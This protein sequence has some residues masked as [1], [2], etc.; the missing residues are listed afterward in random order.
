MVVNK[1]LE[2][3]EIK[4]MG[5]TQPYQKLELYVNNG[6]LEGKK[7]IVE[8]GK[9][10][11]TNLPKYK[12]GD[13]LLV[14]YKKSP[15]GKES[16]F[17][18]DYLRRNSLFW[19]FLI[20]VIVTILIAKFKGLTSLLGMSFSFL[21]VFYFILP[22]IIKGKDPLLTTIIAS[23]LIVPITFYLSHGL[24]KKTTVAVFSTLISLII[25][26]ILAN[27]FVSISKLTGLA[28]EEAGF[29]KVLTGKEIN[30]RGLLLSGIII[31]VI[32]VIDD[33][34]IYQAAIVWQIKE[35]NEKLGFSEVY[36]RAMN[37]GCDHIASM[38]N[39]LVLVYTGV[40]LPL[41]LLFINNPRPFAEVINYEIIASE[42]VR[43]LVGSLGLILA[44][45]IT[46]LVASFV[47]ENGKKIASL[48]GYNS[49]AVYN[50]SSFSYVAM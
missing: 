29:L 41:F 24:N 43:T 36:K 38:I 33:I 12:V 11:L 50:L 2:E 31:G 42:I 7:I 14:S 10:P 25:T 40:S 44:V 19:L 48:T 4:V 35:L 39:T 37:V 47:T 13:E 49:H 27:F 23:L 28:T 32:G 17:I 15:D 3:K 21:V 16:F 6:I 20:F 45:P 8:S 26:G 34:T 30:M 46:T 22:E 5:K 9:M 18:T 1:I